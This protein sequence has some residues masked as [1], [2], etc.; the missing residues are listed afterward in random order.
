VIARPQPKENQ[1][2]QISP[3]EIGARLDRAFDSFQASMDACFDRLEQIVMLG[4]HP[5]HEIKTQGA[6]AAGALNKR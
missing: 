2:E 6:K 4:E 3:E 5:S 1:M